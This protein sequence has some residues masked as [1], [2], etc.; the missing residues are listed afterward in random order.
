[1]KGVGLAPI[2]YGRTIAGLNMPCLVY[3]TCGES[4]DAH[5]L[6][7]QGFSTSPIWKKL[8]GDPQY[9]DNVSRVISIMLKRT[10]ASQI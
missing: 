3:M 7:W 8:T 10:S 9:K 5:K 6:H 4:L 2:F 1:M